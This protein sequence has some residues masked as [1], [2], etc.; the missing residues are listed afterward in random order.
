MNPRGHHSKWIVVVALLMLGM[1]PTYAQF[2]ED[3]LR[4]STLGTGVGARS[5]GMG[6]AYT[7]VASDFSALYWNPAGLAQMQASEFS[8]GLAHLNYQNEGTFYGSTQSFANNATNLNTLG[9]AYSVP[10]QRGSLVFAFGYA[11]QSAFTTGLTF[12]SFNPN[13]SI[14]QT[15]APDGQPYPP[16]ITI[17]EEL[18]LAVADTT[19]GRFISPINGMLTQDGTVLEGGGIDNWSFAGAIDIAKNI[20][21][22]TTLTFLSGSY[23]YDRTYSET[24]SHGAYQTFPFDFN[25]LVVDDFIRSDIS[26]F[27]AKFGL[28]C[29]VPDFFRLG[30]TART[31]TSFHVSEQFG[32]T[33]SSYFDNGD[34]LPTAGPYQ[35]VSNGEYDV[36]TPWVFGAG[37]SLTI[38][39]LVVSADGELTDWTQLKFDNANPDVMAQNSDIKKIFRPAVNLRA[40]AELGFFFGLRFRAGAIY[41]QSPYVMDKTMDYDQKF[42]TGGL[43]ILLAGST[44][45]DMAYAYGW[46]LTNRVNYDTTSPVD[47]S[48][49]TNNFLLTVSYRFQ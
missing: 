48:I 38:L 27:N 24:D 4:F 31:P 34:I 41:N 46:W 32:T 35:S 25:K 11:R 49:H 44:M 28:M 6:N 18:G 45:I 12:S 36:I 15:W 20:S 13:S 37:A 10:V 29:R 3:A 23:S 26:G 1:S 30:L 39:N 43:G 40:G 14:I 2:P 16:N 17:A 8:F 21:A 47:E 22:G 9:M 5:L 42:L 19:T 33:A 7:G